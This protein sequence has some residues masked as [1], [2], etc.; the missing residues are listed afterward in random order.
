MLSVHPRQSDSYSRSAGQDD[1]RSRFHMA[2][3]THPNE[4]NFIGVLVYQTESVAAA[5]GLLT[6]WVRRAPE[7]LHVQNAWDC[8]A[9]DA[10]GRT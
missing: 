1:G 5:M 2:P 3:K 9:S 7:I 6:H 4:V 8:N 10:V